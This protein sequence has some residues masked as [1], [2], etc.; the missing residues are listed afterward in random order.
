MAQ[1][2]LSWEL[3][4]LI[5]KLDCLAFYSIFFERSLVFYIFKFTRYIFFSF[6]MSHL[7]LQR[8]WVSQ[9]STPQ[10]SLLR[11]PNWRTTSDQQ[12]S[13][14]LSVHSRERVP[15][16]SLLFLCYFVLFAWGNSSGGRA[17]WSPCWMLMG[18]SLLVL[19]GGRGGGGWDRTTLASQP[20]HLDFTCGLKERNVS[21]GEKSFKRGKALS[22][23]I[24]LSKGDSNWNIFSFLFSSFNK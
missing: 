3:V 4:P 22:S 18:T 23:H 8:N 5:W 15:C 21:Y 16:C 24:H 12:R 7:G 11:N 10:C 19:L 9:G 1:E 13:F 2:F 6:S 14:I 17:V 20:G